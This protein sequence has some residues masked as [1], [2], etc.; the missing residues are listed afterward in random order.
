MAGRARRTL[1][2]VAAA[3]AVA[4]APTGLGPAPPAAAQ[5][6]GDEAA[7][8]DDPGFV[9]QWGLR[10]IGAP[11]AWQVATGAGTTIAVVDSGV[12]VDHP[13]L[14]GQVVAAADCVGHDDAPG[15][16]VT[17]VAPD[18]SG[19]G[20]HVAGV[21]AAATGNGRGIAG[22]APGARLLA[23]RVLTDRCSD[24]PQPGCEAAGTER[25]VAEGVR[26]AVEHGADVVNLSLGGVA[27]GAGDGELAAALAEAWARGVIPVVV[28]G[29]QLFDPA[30]VPAVVVAATDR[31]DRRS[32][33][34]APVEGARW[35]VAAPGGESDTPETCAS[36]A[37]NGILS[38]YPGDGS[39]E[40]GY[41]CVAGTSMAAPHVAGALAVLR[42]AGFDP[43]GAVDRLVATAADLGAPGHDPEFG[44]GRIDLARALGGVAP[45]G[46]PLQ[47]AG[48]PPAPLPP[49]PPSSRATGTSSTAPSGSSGTTGTAGSGDRGSEVG[50]PVTTPAV[51]APEAPP[52]SSA[53]GGG[54]G[55]DGEPVAGSAP[56]TTAAGG[57]APGGSEASP[58]SSS[59]GGEGEAGEDEQAVATAP[60]RRQGGG[61]DL[62]AGLVTVAVLLVVGVLFAHGWHHLS[63]ADWARRT[64]PDR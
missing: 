44:A 2:A 52:A 57:S 47:A 49:A 8:V 58:S 4:L 37:P 10:R 14:S 25:D 32:R 50:V 51:P 11:A 62:P 16:C 48:G 46:Q 36:R 61:N 42:S 6:P 55:G 13:D 21:A 39:G 5:A 41:A 30:E 9:R 35:A 12:A 59:T 31:E 64:P 22:V 3:T 63:H 43:Q 15:G 20:T 24:D 23:V 1:A 38:T 40:G 28:A 18:V 7:P 27:R 26:W 34:S 54:G 53:G 29:S 45:T 17:G 60:G 56:G 19:H 33:Y